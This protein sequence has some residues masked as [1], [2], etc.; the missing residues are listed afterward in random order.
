MDVWPAEDLL[1]AYS[2]AITN[3]L[4]ISAVLPG[5][6]NGEALKE[7]L[8]LAV[9][10]LRAGEN[11]DDILRDIVQMRAFGTTT[12][13]AKAAY[14]NN[15]LG[16]ANITT[17]KGED[18]VDFQNTFMVSLQDMGVTQSDAFPYAAS[19]FQRVYLDTLSKAPHNPKAAVSAAKDSMANNNIRIRGSIVPKARGFRPEVN[20]DYLESWLRLNYPKNNDATLVVVAQQPN[21]EPVFAVRNAEGAAI[22][23]TRGGVGQI[24]LYSPADINADAVALPLFIETVREERSRR[25]REP[26]RM[27]GRNKQVDTGW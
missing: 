16:F 27:I 11:S 7:T 20:E 17:G 3:G 25:L 23:P 4:P 10:R 8:D 2:S 12:Q 15:P 26:V 1:Y 19:E 21:G 5:G 9:T 22:P 18:G 14:T 6:P 24:R 13:I